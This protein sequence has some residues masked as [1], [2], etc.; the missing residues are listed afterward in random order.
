LLGI[1]AEAVF[2]G[3]SKYC[4]PGSSVRSNR[5]NF[6]MTASIV[7]LMMSLAIDWSSQLDFRDLSQQRDWISDWGLKRYT[8]DIDIDWIQTLDR[9]RQN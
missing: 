8:N 4:H 6:D 5:A 1:G 2:S 3:R 9:I 7:M